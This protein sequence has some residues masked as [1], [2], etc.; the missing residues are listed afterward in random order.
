MNAV[1]AV[2]RLMADKGHKLLMADK[3]IRPLNVMIAVMQL[4]V[5]NGR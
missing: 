5:V 3:G 4:L 1:V 2:M